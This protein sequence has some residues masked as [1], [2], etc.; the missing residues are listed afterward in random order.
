MNLRSHLQTPIR[1]HSVAVLLSV[2]LVGS[3]VIQICCVTGCSQAAPPVVKET[4]PTVDLGEGSDW[5][6]FLGPDGTGVA[7]ESD[8]VDTWPKSGPPIL[9]E[10]RIGTGYSAPSVLGHRLVVH[11]RPR[12][13]GEVV[14]CLRADTGEP[15][16]KYTYESEFADPY[17]YN[18]G[19][20][21]SPLLTNE[22]CYTYGAGGKLA[23]VNLETGEKIW[24]RDVKA[25]FSIPDWFFGIGCTP[26]LEGNL[27]IALVGGVA[28]LRCR[29]LRRGNGQDRLGS[30]RQNHVGRCR[31]ERLVAKANLFMDRDRA[32]R[33]LLLA[34]RC[35]DSRKASRS[36]FDAPKASCRSIP[37]TAV[38]I[39]NT[40]FAPPRTNRST[41]RGRL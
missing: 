24:M 35:N 3:F 40:S 14:E 26:I 10:K 29:G 41:R 23:C 18:N 37:R 32:G 17:G 7:R 31:N 11:H 16:W 34:D 25:D 36:L 2:S 12:G 39:S 30:G 21:C 38:R 1:L 8:I 13:Q 27:L 19:P 15:I 5:P 9:W 28:K 6:I 20:R 4:S 22:R 33:Q